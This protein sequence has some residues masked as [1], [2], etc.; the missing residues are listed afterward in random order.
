MRKSRGGRGKGKEGERRWGEKENSKKAELSL[1]G[2]EPSG[3][4]KEVKNTKM[5]VMRQFRQIEE[6][7]QERGLL[8]G[9]S[10]FQLSSAS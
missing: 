2:W 3:S 1:I 10:P 8:C 7:R 6:T 4:R 5:G 9:Q